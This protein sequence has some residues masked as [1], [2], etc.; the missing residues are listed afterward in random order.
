[1]HGELGQGDSHLA[2]LLASN[3]RAANQIKRIMISPLGELS[4]QSVIYDRD[5]KGTTLSQRS[6]R[7]AAFT[8]AL[9]QT[10]PRG[11]A[12]SSLGRAFFLGLPRESLNIT[13]NL[14]IDLQFTLRYE[15][16]FD[17]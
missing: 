7:L 8:H 1:M 3:L 12:Q 15:L 4:R 16:A 14:T 10:F 11:P 17:R 2:K 5:R 9:T 6:D 13:L